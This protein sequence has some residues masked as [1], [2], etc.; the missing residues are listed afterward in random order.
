[1]ARPADVPGLLRILAFS[2][3]ATST[4]TGSAGTVVRAA[5]AGQAAAGPRRI[6]RFYLRSR[7]HWQHWQFRYLRWLWEHESGWNRY[8]SN[9]YSGA[10]GIPQALPGSKMASA[11]PD[12]RTDARTQVL[13]G[14][15][16]IKDRYGSPYSAWQH[17]QS[18]GWY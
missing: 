18:W 16:Y 2:A 11:G 5:H 6:A 15:T 9:P 14:M 12:W 10:Y 4:Q 13:W 8:A 7:F 3:G 1:M 17:E